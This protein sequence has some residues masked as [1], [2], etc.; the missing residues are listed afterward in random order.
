MTKSNFSCSC[1]EL[2]FFAP[3]F[4]WGPLVPSPAVQPFVGLW[5]CRYIFDPRRHLLQPGHPSSFFQDWCSLLVWISVGRTAPRWL[6]SSELWSGAIPAD[7]YRLRSG[8][9]FLWISSGWQIESNPTRSGFRCEPGAS[10]PEAFLWSL[11]CFS[12][13]CS[14]SGDAI[15]TAHFLGSKACSPPKSRFEN[16]ALR[17]IEPV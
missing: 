4:P 15:C 14:I 7:F 2:L 3:L 9:S 6:V 13:E 1:F 10:H 8:L 11:H 17:T 5:G 12:V 16:L